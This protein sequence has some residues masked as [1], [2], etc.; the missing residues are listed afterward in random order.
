MRAVHWR[1]MIVFATTAALWMFS[2]VIKPYL[3]VLPLTG[4][5]IPLTDEII[6][7]GA[8]IALFVV[9]GEGKQGKALLDWEATQRL[10]WGIL[11]LFGGGLSMASGLE[12]TGVIQMLSNNMETV[13]GGNTIP[14]LLLLSALAL[15]LTEVMSNVAMI[16][17]LV[18]VVAA[19]AVAMDSD[20]LNF[21]VPVTL[22]SS[23]GTCFLWGLRL[24]RS[25]SLLVTSLYGK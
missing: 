15:Y 21:A 7:I 1:M 10:P 5:P 12:K 11:L 19:V 20:P 25:C 3:P 18:P 17:V 14:L 13:A 4:Q 6:A 2:G 23:C 24:T 9:P 22:A 8:A 16:Q